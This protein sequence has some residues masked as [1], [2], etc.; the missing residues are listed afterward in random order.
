MEEQP[1]SRTL[2]SLVHVATTCPDMLEPEAG[3]KPYTRQT[4]FAATKEEQLRTTDG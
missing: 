4:T 2:F 1:L 3:Y